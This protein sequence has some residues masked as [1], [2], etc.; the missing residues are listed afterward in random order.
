MKTFIVYFLIQ[1]QK[2]T[3]SIKLQTFWR[4][5]LE[6]NRKK[7]LMATFWVK[8]KYFEALYIIIYNKA[9][10]KSI[11]KIHFKCNKVENLTL[12]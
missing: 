11:K 12:Y 3:F 6:F 2:Y 1:L 7:L 9:R 8:I 5:I 4:K 10:V